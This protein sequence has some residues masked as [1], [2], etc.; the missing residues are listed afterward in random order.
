M[1]DL[2]GRGNRRIP[3]YFEN[4]DVLVVQDGF[5]RTIDIYSAKVLA[6]KWLSLGKEGFSDRYGF[7]WEPSE[8][9]KNRVRMHQ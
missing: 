2:D 8:L 5:G 4:I 3:R 7:P 9:L 6:R 1:P